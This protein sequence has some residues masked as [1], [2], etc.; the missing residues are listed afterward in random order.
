LNLSKFLITG[1]AGFIGF[2]LV[3]S[4]IKMGYTVVGIDNL[5]EYTDV[6]I[7]LDRLKTSGIHTE[8]VQ[9]NT[10]MSSNKSDY[11][12]IQLDITDLQNLDKLFKQEQFTYV[13]NLA[14]HAGVRNSITNPH[15]Y[16]QSNIV[17]FTNILECCRHH[18]IKHLLYASSSS[19][20]G[21]NIKT[22]FSEN[23]A[24]D[25][26]ISLYA[27]SKKANE[28]MAHSYSHLYKLPTTALR[29]FTVYGPW[30]RPDMAP[31]LFATAIA[32]QKA[33][34]VFNN[35]D[36]IRDFTYI[37]DIVNGII[38]LIDYIPTEKNEHPYYQLLNIGNAQ[39]ISLLTFITSL[40]NA[41]GKTTEK[42]MM[43]MQAGDVLCT[44]ADIERIKNTI[45]FTPKTDL[46]EGLTLFVDWF[47]TYYKVE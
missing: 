7:K 43:P 44:W 5:N 8:N 13:I 35:G 20:Y 3:E 47:K 11:T 33:I 37:D 19:V 16:V 22:P 15:A 6:T 28:L 17:G 36:L 31:F 38:K 26:P 34:K 24:T 12:F 21:N 4:L 29:F 39:K 32:Q 45:A 41:M 25:Y 14:A 42:I 9:Y 10:K 23:D 30:G 40:E 1:S 2:H 27:A 46:Q 18:S